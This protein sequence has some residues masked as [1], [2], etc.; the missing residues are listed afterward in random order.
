[1][2]K[3]VNILLQILR[4]QPWQ[5]GFIDHVITHHEDATGG[6][7]AETLEIKKQSFEP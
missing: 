3:D 6:G 2:A 5:E 1:L 4:S 7:I